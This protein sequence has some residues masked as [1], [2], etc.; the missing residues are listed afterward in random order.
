[1]ALTVTL[2]RLRVLVSAY[3]CEPERGSEPGV[4]W[5][6]TTAIARRHDVWL[7]TRRNNVP[8]IQKA[9]E[10]DPV[11]G[12]TVIGYDL[13]TWARFWKRG[14][15]G[16]QPYYYLW[17]IGAFVCVRRLHRTL[18]FDL[19]HHVTFVKYWMPSLMAL[20]PIPFIWGPVG[21]G[22]STPPRFES[23][24][25]LGGRFYELARRLGRWLGER[26]PL[27]HLTARRAAVTLAATAETAQRLERLG[28]R[29]VIEMPAVALPDSE[30]ETLSTHPIR[31][32][33]NVRF[34]SVG[35]LQHL[36]GFELALRAFAK[37]EL[38][39]C[40]YWLAGDGPERRRLEQLAKSLGCLD[41]I[42][43]CGDLPR[44]RLLELLSE[45]DVLVHP[46]LHESGS[47]AC[48]EA[49]AAARPVICF[50]IGGPGVLVTSRCGIKVA[51]HAPD[52]AVEDFASAMRALA[53]NSTLRDELG[54]AAR[55][56][57]A[58]S[59][60]WRHKTEAILALYQEA[61]ASKSK[62]SPASPRARRLGTGR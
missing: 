27:V 51:A 24:L 36:K 61:C 58:R 47:W 8:A 28:A 59:F 6:M 46:G 37:A 42:R 35:R 30:L 31:Q 19:A 50:D 16:I 23:A 55:E 34:L 44:E 38:Q 11:P 7:V 9:L 2:E 15:R 21:G 48:L 14:Q 10:E 17:Q 32:Q 54:S 26:D 25:R 57:V 13:P 18:R 43:F 40:E 49:M 20:L 5:H 53:R 29:R 4:G 60:R 33:P 41:R 39:H 3:A 62:V 52:Q 1:V 45:C 22:E 56:H 12:L